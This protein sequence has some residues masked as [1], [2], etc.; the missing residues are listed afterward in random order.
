MRKTLQ[1]QRFAARREA[2]D[3]DVTKAKFDI[4]DELRVTIGKEVRL[5][6][7][8]I[9]VGALYIF[10]DTAH[11]M[12]RRLTR[13]CVRLPPF[14]PGPWCLC[15]AQV[16]HSFEL[17]AVVYASEADGYPNVVIVTTLSVCAA[18][19]LQHAPFYAAANLSRSGCTCAATFCNCAFLQQQIV[20]ES[21]NHTPKRGKEAWS[22]VVC[23]CR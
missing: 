1:A 14:A 3:K 20:V 21:A 4:S 2:T 8:S 7:H 17:A 15:C 11:S 10:M 23:C 19:P 13:P 6:D 12:H 16:L 18:L 5:P 9:G 22:S